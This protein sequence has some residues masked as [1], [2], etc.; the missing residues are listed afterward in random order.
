M[1]RA[2]VQSVEPQVAD[3]VNNQLRGY[4]L[5]YKLEQESINQQ[6]D[7]ALASYASKNGG[8]GATVLM[9]SYSSGIRS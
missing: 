9:P 7:D 8:G 1:G 6:I 3:F 4:G 2:K 5:D